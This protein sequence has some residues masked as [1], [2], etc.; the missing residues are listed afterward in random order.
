MSKVHVFPKDRDAPERYIEIIGTPFQQ[1]FV[2]KPS[3]L[4]SGV[5]STCLLIAIIVFSFN[6]ISSNKHPSTDLKFWLK[7]GALIG[8][9]TL[10]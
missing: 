7:G 9:K 10:N 1:Y 3:T 8:N 4:Q 2:S 5:P 6:L